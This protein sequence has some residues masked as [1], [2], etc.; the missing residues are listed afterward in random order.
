MPQASVYYRTSLSISQE[1]ME[2]KEKLKNYGYI[3][4]FRAGLDYLCEK[5][6]I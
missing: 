4:I 1:E 3:D 6:G 5:E 2:L